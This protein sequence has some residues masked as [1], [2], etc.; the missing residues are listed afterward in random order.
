M[1]ASALYGAA[2]QN[3]KPELIK[4]V[5][6]AGANPN[7][8]ESLYHSLVDPL[9]ARLLLEAAAAALQ[10]GRRSR[11]NCCGKLALPM[12]CLP[13]SNSLWSVRVGRNAC[14]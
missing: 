10:Y 1:P 2:G 4:L 8:G 5:L 6:R 9:C 14:T 11:Q 7:D 3:R 12:N 13:R